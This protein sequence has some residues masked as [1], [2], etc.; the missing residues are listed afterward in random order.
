M[1]EPRPADETRRPPSDWR[2]WLKVGLLIGTA[3]ATGA[4]WYNTSHFQSLAA[5][6]QAGRENAAE[7][8]AIMGTIADIRASLAASAVW[9]IEFARRFD[10]HEGPKT[11]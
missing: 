1:K 2:E 3:L 5:A 6:E 7:H 8:K 9:Q 11:P 4:S 10:R